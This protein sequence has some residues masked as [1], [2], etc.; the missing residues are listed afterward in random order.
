GDDVTERDA[1]TRT[2]R[3]DSAAVGAALDRS[4]LAP[5]LEVT[6]HENPLD[7]AP[8]PPPPM[9]EFDDDA[10]LPPLIATA[11]GHSGVAFTRADVNADRPPPPTDQSWPDRPLSDLA[12]S[13]DIS[14]RP[15]VNDDD[16]D[17]PSL[18]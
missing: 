6:L 8:P 17:P 4:G 3:V 7:D 5:A 16:E 9:T 11:S 13:R 14:E 15:L 2:R 10:S 1:P 18:D 12:V